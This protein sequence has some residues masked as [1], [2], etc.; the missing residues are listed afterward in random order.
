MVKLEQ[1][2]GQLPWR[3]KVIHVYVAVRGATAAMTT[4][5]SVET[6]VSLATV[7]SHRSIASIY[8]YL[9]VT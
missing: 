1:V 9:Q 6:L 7:T 4:V 8:I 2:R 5:E 3:L